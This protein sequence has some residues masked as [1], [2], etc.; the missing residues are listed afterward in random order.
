[1][2]VCR[3]Y[4]AACSSKLSWLRSQDLNLRTQLVPP[5]QISIRLSFS[6]GVRRACLRSG[7]SWR[8]LA[9]DGML[10]VIDISKRGLTY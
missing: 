10:Q 6:A 8:W 7:R 3:F 9:F 1:V 5:S 2:R 4:A